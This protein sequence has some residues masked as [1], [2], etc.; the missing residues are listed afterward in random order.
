[1]YWKL[2]YVDLAL[3]DLD[4]VLL[5]KRV[6]DLLVRDRTVEL[7]A[8]AGLALDRDRDLLQPRRDLLGLGPPRVRP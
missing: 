4:G 7:R 5:R 1:M 2:P 6:R 3:V 8:R